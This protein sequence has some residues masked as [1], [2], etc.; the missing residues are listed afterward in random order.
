MRSITARWDKNALTI[1]SRRD[2]TKIRFAVGKYEKAS[3]PELVDLKITDYCS[4]GCS[5]CY[6]DSSLLGKHAPF[7]NIEFIADELARARV[8]EVAIGGG[9][10][11]EYPGIVDVLRAFHSRGVIPNFTTK[12]PAKVRKLWPEI[13]SLVGGFAYSAENA[14][15]VEMAARVL[16]TIPSE[17]VSLHYV[18]GLGDRAHFEDYMRAANRAGYRVTLLGYKTTGRGKDLAPQPY[19]WWIDSVSS[20]VRDGECPSLSIDTPLAE[21]YDGKMP[22]PDYLYHT[23]EGKFSMYV[24]AVAM[25][26]GASS[27]DEDEDLVPF[28]RDWKKAYRQM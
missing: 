25:T 28:S 21:Q 1:F 3:R 8:F 23:N 16:H 13:S 11:L 14:L 18:M 26:F 24:D 5:F 10:P 9:D 19:D 20:L 15:Q 27:F 22:V 6:Q 7:E 12:F 2:G 4:F 17:K